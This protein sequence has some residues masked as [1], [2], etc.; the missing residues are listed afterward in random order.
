MCCCLCFYHGREFQ[1]RKV[2]FCSF[3]HS[4]YDL[5]D[6]KRSH[7]SSFLFV[8]LCQISFAGMALMFGGLYFVLWA[9]GKE[10]CE[11][12]DEMKQ[13]D[14]ESLLRTEFD[15]QKPLLL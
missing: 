9:K 13:D 10:D 1:P 5:L 14:E 6:R 4:L 3:S 11:E 12:I 7:L 15:L 2:H 8:F